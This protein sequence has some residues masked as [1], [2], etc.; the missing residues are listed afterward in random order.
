MRGGGVAESTCTHTSAPP[1]LERGGGGGSVRAAERTEKAET[2]SSQVLHY[3]W[4]HHVPQRPETLASQSFTAPS[5]THDHPSPRWGA[6][7]GPSGRR[8]QGLA[9]GGL[10]DRWADLKSASG[11]SQVTTQEK[12]EG[13]VG[14]EPLFLLAQAMGKR[15]REGPARA[16]ARYLTVRSLRQASGGGAVSAVRRAGVHSRGAK[17]VG[18][19]GWGLQ[20]ATSPC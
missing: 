18:G 11:T 6:Q 7:R 4:L 19:G 9:A 13:G 3:H 8:D 14:A 10:P 12:S 16:A 5:P 15:A 17:G 2:T 1:H 20:A